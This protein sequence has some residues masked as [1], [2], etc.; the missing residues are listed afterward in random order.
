M[1]YTPEVNHYVYWNHK[2]EGWVYFKGKEY[3]TIELNV[4]PK[5]YENYA[6]CNLHRNDRLLVLCYNNQWNELQYVRSRESV[7]EEEKEYVEVMGEGTWSEG[8]EK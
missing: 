7:Y 1:S 4:K 6:A 5:N 8:D 3:I 2:V